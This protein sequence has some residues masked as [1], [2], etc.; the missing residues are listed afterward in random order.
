MPASAPLSLVA[1]IGGTYSRVA[2]AKG[3]QVLEASIRRYRNAEEPGLAD[4]LQSYVAETGA[5][6]EAACLA[7]AGPVRGGAGKLTNLDWAIDLPGL[8]RSTG[9]PRVALLNDLEAQGHALEA[10]PQ[11]AIRELRPGA[12]APGD[13]ARLVLEMGTGFNIAAVHTGPGGRC[14]AASESGHA[15]LPCFSESD[16]DL[17]RYLSGGSPRASVEQALSGPGLERLHGW[18]TTRAGTPHAASGPEIMQGAAAGEPAAL[19]TLRLF[20]RLLGTVAGDLALI[21]LPFGGIYLTGGVGRAVA[22]HL[23]GFGFAEAFADK[24]RFAG[25]MAAFPIFVIEDDAAALT[26]CAAYLAGGAS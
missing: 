26:G 10:L 8:R 16:L 24:G 6:P 21:T 11:G 15:S 7:L 12:P 4:V 9:A 5:R 18:L 2:L 1:D 23:P 3:G 13:A 25:L 20:V 14:V 19:E 22:P 17:A